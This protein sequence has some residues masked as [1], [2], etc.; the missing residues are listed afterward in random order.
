MI[1]VCGI[2]HQSARQWIICGDTGQ[3]VSVN[4]NTIKDYIVEKMLKKNFKKYAGQTKKREGVLHMRIGETGED[5]SNVYEWIAYWI[6]N[7]MSN[8]PYHKVSEYHKVCEVSL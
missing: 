1:V 7:K 4:C 5:E 3:N 2:Q 6:E 8:Y